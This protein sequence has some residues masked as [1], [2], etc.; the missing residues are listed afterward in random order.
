MDL[1]LY[2]RKLSL[3]DGVGR[4]YGLSMCMWL[5]QHAASARLNVYHVIQIFFFFFFWTDSSLF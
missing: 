3:D 1:V 2:Q 4:V 5:K